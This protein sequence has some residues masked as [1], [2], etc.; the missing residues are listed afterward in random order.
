LRMKPYFFPLHFS[1]TTATVDRAE[2]LLSITVF[3]LSICV[4]IVT[5]IQRINNPTIPDNPVMIVPRI[6]IDSLSVRS[7][8]DDHDGRV[9]NPWLDFPWLCRWPGICPCLC[10]CHD[11]IMVCLHSLCPCHSYRL[12]FRLSFHLDFSLESEDLKNLVHGFASR[13]VLVPQRFNLIPSAPKCRRCR[14]SCRHVEG[15]GIVFDFLLS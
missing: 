13:C 4:V 1:M 8:L 9:W 3:A 11:S 7:P 5:I 6:A 10:L 14:L 15:P 12:P 2:V